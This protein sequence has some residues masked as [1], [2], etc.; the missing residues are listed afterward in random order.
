MSHLSFKR[1]SLCLS[2]TGRVFGTHAA[3]ILEYTAVSCITITHFLYVVVVVVVPVVVVVVVVV[4]VMVLWHGVG[5]GVGVG[6]VGVVG[7]VGAGGA[8]GVGLVLFQ[9]TR[10]RT[11]VNAEDCGKSFAKFEKSFVLAD[12][13]CHVAKTPMCII[14]RKI[15]KELRFC[16]FF[17]PCREAGTACRQ[18]C[19]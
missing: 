15:R 1:C 16:R 14:V 6:V 13:S 10:M 18:N 5:V 7:V 11:S 12:F 3:T 9:Q 2:D 8:G 19:P 17:L 4:V